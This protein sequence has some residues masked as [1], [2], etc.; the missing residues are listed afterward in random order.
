MPSNWTGRAMTNRASLTIG[1]V[2]SR[3]YEMQAWRSPGCIALE[4]AVWAPPI[5]ASPVEI[6]PP[7]KFW[8]MQPFRAVAAV[9]TIIATLVRSMMAAGIGG[10]TAVEFDAATRVR[11]NSIVLDPK[12]SV[13]KCY[14][15]TCP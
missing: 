14:N 6:M 10:L 3:A 1:L 2:G 12:F 13:Q 11:A 5:S 7:A 4:Q 15:P 8:R 9:G